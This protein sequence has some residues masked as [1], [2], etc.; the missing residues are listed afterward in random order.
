MDRIRAEAYRLQ[1][2]KEDF[3]FKK[4]IG[5]EVETS[6]IDVFKFENLDCQIDYQGIG[7]KDIIISNPLNGKKYFIKLKSLLPSNIDKNVRVSI[8]QRFMV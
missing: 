8:N 1:S 6:L 7:D 2:E 5:Q 3:E 4:A